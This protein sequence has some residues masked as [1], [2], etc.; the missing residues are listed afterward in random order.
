MSQ[1]IIVTTSPWKDHKKNKW[2]LSAYMSIQLDAGADT[3]L[4]AFPDI[5]GWMDRLQQATFFVQ[6]DNNVPA[7]IT[8]LNAKWD[9]ALYEKLFHGNINV[10]SFAPL[11]ISKL[12][13][14]SYPAIHV[15]DFIMDTYKTVGSM[16]TDELPKS[17]FYHTEY[18]GLK[19]LTQ[20]QLRQTQPIT[21]KRNAATINDFVVKGNAGRDV[22]RQ[23]VKQN[24]AIGFSKTANP[25]MDLG[26]FHNF[27]SPVDKTQWKAPP[28][29]PK[30]EFEYHD[31]LSIIT[32]Y[33][34]ILR[35]LGLV[36]DFE[37]AGPPP[38]S[39]GTVR[40]LPA[41]LSFVNDVTLSSPASAYQY[42]G[43]GFFAASKPGSFIEKGMLRVNTED[44]S[45]IQLDTDG[46]A[47]KLASH[48]DTV[49]LNLAKS[50]V[51][52][53]NFI[54]PLVFMN[55]AG[56][57]PAV[58]DKPAEDDDQDTDEA[59]PSLR[60]AGIGIVKNGLA[61]HLVKKFVR[62]TD[63]YKI[64]INPAF[65][66]NNAALFNKVDASAIKTQPT[67]NVP[68][69]PV[70]QPNAAGGK[71][72]NAQQIR[73]IPV[74]RM[75]DI[76]KAIRQPAIIPVATEILYADDLVFG[77]R[78][79][80]AYDDKPDTWYSL[81][82]RKNSY[83]F[84]PVGGTEQPIVP[85]A[86]DETDEGC[87]HLSLAQDD[88]DPEQDQKIS[89][90]IA[91]W[92]GWSLS[93]PRIGKGLNN[94]GTEVSSDADEKSKYDL[95]KDMPF[96]LQVKI[97]PAPKSL[98]SLRFGRLYRI[99]VR[100]VDIAG[101]GLPHDVQ[102]ENPAIAVRA[103]IKY[104]RYEPLSTPVVR[105][106]DEVAGGDRSKM[107]TRDGESLQHLVIRSNVG[108]STEDYEKKNVTTIVLN[109][110]AAGTLTYLPEAVR[111]FTAPRTSQHMAEV[112]GMFDN[113][114][115][116]PQ[117]A[118]E[119]YA[120]IKS[121]DKEWKDD[122]STKAAEIPVSTGQV[123]IDY[124][125]DP[126]AAGVVFTLKSATGFETPWPKGVSRKFSFY[127]DEEV[128]DGN[129]NKEYS[130]DQWRSPRSFKIRMVEGHGLPEWKG[131]VLTI[132]LPKSA[133]IE[134]NYACFWR[135]ADLDKVSA[136]LPGL[137][138]GGGRSI[139][140]ARGGVHW[141]F[142]PWRMLR[143]VHAVQQPLEKPAFD[144]GATT[145]GKQ[146]NDTFATINT[147]VSV[148]GSSTDKTDIEAAWQEMVDDVSELHPKQIDIR[149]HVDTLPVD[150]ADKL[151]TCSLSP[152]RFP[153]GPVRPMI[154]H[155]FNDTKHRWVNYTPVATTRYREYFTGVIETAKR[156]GTLDKFLLTQTG[157]TI[158]LNVLS[159]A[160]PVIPVVDYLVPSFNWIR[161]Q[162]GNV[163]NHVRTANIRVY[164]KRPWYSSGD[165]EKIAVILPPKGAEP[166]RN[167]VLKKYCTV[168]GKDPVFLAP[169][170]NN[171]NYP[172]VDHFPFAADYD[173][174]KLAEEDVTV[175][176]AAYKV[177]F[178][179]EKQL[180][181]ADIPVNTG[182][183]YFPFIKFSL[184]RYQRHSVRKDGKDCCLSNM[185]VTDWMQVVAGRIT[186]LQQ[187]SSKNNFSV[188][189]K[190]VAPFSSN[191]DQFPGAS[192]NARVKIN[193]TVENTMF[194]KTDDAFV[195]IISRQGSSMIFTKDFDLT[196][197]D[198]R[199][200][201]I[202]FL[203]RIELP[204]AW[205]GQ[206]YR[207]VV[208]EYEL[209]EDDPLRVQQKAL[210]NAVI[211][212]YGE[213]L[214]FMDVFEVNGTV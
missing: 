13:I 2:M 138:K 208:R 204:A 11:D 71:V 114:F 45:V 41:N 104:L 209:H 30:P 188:S 155:S 55:D 75:T 78:L 91:R 6:W 15:H 199:N 74:A 108:V 181:Y 31:I 164:L 17:S 179:A 207:V 120:F 77:Y 173:N 37:L 68:G 129:V 27:H 140:H 205:A 167:P 128:T 105:Q 150:Y 163:M 212:E 186:S 107:R 93:V 116:T 165:E 178:D 47:M 141:M 80:I 118:K 169:D 200:G 110:A 102:P 100:T 113:A 175:A 122:G 103:G 4:S 56:T 123:D 149:T 63:I 24:K 36:I 5:Q 133:K 191:P 84:V 214:V 14:K 51:M 203:Q 73:K 52:K 213:R 121:K 32:S 201:T 39:S 65:T 147:K 60:S 43:N 159:S 111:F 19:P 210:T 127:F 180:H 20:V 145:I 136:I 152:G 46:A 166:L 115:R 119:A 22:A 182:F 35:K 25:D 153:Q 92:E 87:I 132:P 54:T 117:G 101:N 99:K 190:G 64:M 109:G 112:H 177:M 187:E 49:N 126:M 135:P 40:I 192:N 170:L 81:H 90:V 154:R 156:N 34:F 161:E 89:E 58:N 131:R 83:A 1:K 148:H 143:L 174:V 134:V 172:Q 198:V 67:A 194:P 76:G 50:L 62:N 171:S 142:S 176:V 3:K 125:A 48:A 183:A 130:S 196:Y 28:F 26:Q 189:V 211:H 79:D 168:W 44:F 193:I 21:N 157:E 146:F 162:K 197:R 61:E 10:K 86:G 160:R 59:L 53:S 94:T 206:P 23:S 85:D 95:D 70:T 66:T 144:K 158:K 69:A 72:I 7:D 106:G 139:A 33:P 202:D 12:V 42:T 82:K 16:K 195:S 8:P 98:P 185:V 96:R 57:Q 151:L 137:V 97:G 38:A 184:A 9:K 18:T 88:N 124:L 29:I